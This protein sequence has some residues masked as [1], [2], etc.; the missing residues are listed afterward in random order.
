M[1]TGAV[2]CLYDD[3]ADLLI[4]R[5]LAWST[6]AGSIL[7]STAGGSA[8]AQHG[9][10][11]FSGALGFY[12]PV[13]IWGLWLDGHAFYMRREITRRIAAHKHQAPATKDQHQ[14]RA[15]RGVLAG[16]AA[17]HRSATT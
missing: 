13:A 5:W 15:E 2:V 3:R 7:L 1:I 11:A 17:D 9:A 10:F 14:A 8:F 16:V 4:P 12:L 6:I